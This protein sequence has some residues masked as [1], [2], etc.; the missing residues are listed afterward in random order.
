MT[1]FTLYEFEISDVE[2]P[3]QLIDFYIFSHIKN[4]ECGQWI[5]DNADQIY[6]NIINHEDNDFSQMVIVKAEF[7]D[8]LATEFCLRRESKK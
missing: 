1:A 3:E 5:L 8:K 6:Y 2:D 4:T 7:N